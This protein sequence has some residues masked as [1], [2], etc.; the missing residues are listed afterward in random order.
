MLVGLVGLKGNGKSEV[1]KFLER[2]LGFRRTRFADTLKEM[3]AVLLAAQGLSDEDIE[4]MIDGDLKE[5]PSS[6]LGNKTPTY[7]MQTLG[8]EWGRDLI[9]YDMW[10]NITMNQI[11]RTIN[12]GHSV[13]VDDVRFK[14]EYDLVR[15]LGGYIINIVGRSAV[16]QD[17][18][19]E[20]FSWLDHVDATISNTGTLD[21]LFTMAEGTINAIRKELWAP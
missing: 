18:V 11:T 1:A 10:L 19:S 5:E 4:R 14:N 13:V 12:D 9:D 21:Q 3:L 20:K 2:A 17:H 16:V 6:Y 7:A 8:T 15:G